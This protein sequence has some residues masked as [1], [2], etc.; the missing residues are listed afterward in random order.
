MF[1]ITED[2]SRDEIVEL[3]KAFGHTTLLPIFLYI[4]GGIIPSAF[5]YG[6]VLTLYFFIFPEKEGGKMFFTM[7]LMILMLLLLMILS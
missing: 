4:V 7:H 5:Y 6:F 1:G 2:L 3:A